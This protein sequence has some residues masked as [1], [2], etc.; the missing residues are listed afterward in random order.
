[1]GLLAAIRPLVRSE[2][3]LATTALAHVLARSA[4]A[5]AAFNAALG[6]DAQTRWSPQHFFDEGD[7]QRGRPDLVGKTRG[8]VRAFVEAKFHAGL[9]AAQPVRYIRA[10]PAGGHLAFLVPESRLGYLSQEV[11]RRLAEGGATPTDADNR[12]STWDVVLEDGSLRRLSMLTWR[13][14]LSRLDGALGHAEELAARID[15]SQISQLAEEIE[16]QAYVPIAS[17]QL[18]SSEIPRIMLQV[19]D[20]LRLLQDALVGVGYEVVGRHDA[21]V[22]GWSGFVVKRGDQRLRW[23]V[24]SSITAWRDFGITPFWLTLAVDDRRLHPH[25]LED[26]IED[27]AVRGV[28]LS[29]WRHAPI[30]VPIRIPHDAGRDEV[31]ASMLAEVEGYFRR[32]EHMLEA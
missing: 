11:R 15:L 22:A 4:A 1:M 7:D 24:N 25:L 31:I 21:N 23:A 12:S 5:T 26:W 18:T 30:G 2:E 27:D 10:L 20:L 13:S 8:E 19:I 17:E 28:V 14:M 32:A 16:D 29:D 9:T 6:L 3:D